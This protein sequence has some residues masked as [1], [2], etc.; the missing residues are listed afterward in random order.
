[1][2]KVYRIVL[3]GG[4]GSGKSTLVNELTNVGFAAFSEV[5]REVIRQS[6]ELNSDVLP[7]KDVIGF[8]RAVQQGM[9]R[10]YCLVQTGGIYFYD[11]CLL[12]VKAYLELDKYAIYEELNQAI[13]SHKYNKQVFITPP[14]KEIFEQD[15]ERQETFEDAEKAHSQLVHT[16][17]T[18]GYELVEIPRLSPA[19]RVQFICEK[20]KEWGVE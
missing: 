14:W 11:R 9:L 20:L 5:A 3:T 7:W 15:S 4:G 18:H 17:K 2:K 8:S 19:Q 6:V 12:D 1:M 16:Y 10:D 13:T